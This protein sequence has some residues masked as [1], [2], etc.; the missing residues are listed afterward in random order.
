MKCKNCGEMNR[1]N[2]I[3]CSKCGVSLE[4]KPKKT[5]Y[6]LFILGIVE[7]CVVLL[8]F[9]LLFYGI[10]DGIVAAILMACAFSG[11]GVLFFIIFLITQKNISKLIKRLAFIF[12]FLP[13]TIL[14]TTFTLRIIIGLF[15]NNNSTPTTNETLLTEGCFE[16]TEK[17]VIT[18]YL[19][20]D[21]YVEVPS[22]INGTKITTI[23]MD[24]FGYKSKA[25]Y[26]TLPTTVINLGERSFSYSNIKVLIIN[27]NLS[28]LKDE[29]G[30]DIYDNNIFGPTTS[31]LKIYTSEYNLNT[32]DWKK[33]VGSNN[34]YSNNCKENGSKIECKIS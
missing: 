18:E 12:L 27:G 7:Y 24:A 6:I 22:E 33:I 11:L 13:F 31:D 34:W 10:K 9:L 23:G 15:P 25:K 17:G 32:F 30:R 21:N 14:G 16:Y 8:L 2:S 4:N 28:E 1:E 20:S 19:C 26:I 3:Y 5:N 29:Y